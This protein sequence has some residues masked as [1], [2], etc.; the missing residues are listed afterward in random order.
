MVSWIW[1]GGSTNLNGLPC[2]W[3]M[4]ED[5]IIPRIFLDNHEIEG[6]NTWNLFQQQM[7]KSP[8]RRENLFLSKKGMN[9]GRNMLY[10]DVLPRSPTLGGRIIWVV[11]TRDLFFCLNNIVLAFNFRERVNI[12]LSAVNVSR[13]W[14]VRGNF[15]IFLLYNYLSYL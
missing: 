9:I 14:I 12:L 8:E 1:Q 2:M 15:Q 4:P 11:W 7:V 3:V 5:N 6:G 10:L 13:V